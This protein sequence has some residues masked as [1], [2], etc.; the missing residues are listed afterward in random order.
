[1]GVTGRSCFFQ[2]LEKMNR[3]VVIFLFAEQ[4]AKAMQIP[5]R[6][7][8]RQS[9][10][11]ARFQNSRRAEGTNASE[12]I[13]GETANVPKHRFCVIESL[14]ASRQIACEVAL[15]VVGGL[16]VPVEPIR[17]T[18]EPKIALS[19]ICSVCHSVCMNLRELFSSG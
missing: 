19:T 8:H 7:G 17:Q 12:K 13:I 6:N 2:H 15:M 5:S 11:S 3:A 18:G 14:R 4:L 9:E 1:M 10:I 16:S